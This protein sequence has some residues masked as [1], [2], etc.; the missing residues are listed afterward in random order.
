MFIL[1][2]EFT[3]LGVLYHIIAYPQY[4][5]YY[6]DLYYDQ[7]HDE[8]TNSKFFSLWWFLYSFE[9]GAYIAFEKVMFVGPWCGLVWLIVFIPFSGF[10][11]GVVLSSFLGSKAIT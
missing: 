8:N 4:I 9:H 5:S 11:I 3:K 1:I 7:L 2:K 6:F 10:F